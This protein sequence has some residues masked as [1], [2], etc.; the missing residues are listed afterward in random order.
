MADNTENESSAID[1]LKL[2][3]PPVPESSPVK[4]N[5]KTTPDPFPYRHYYAL[6]PTCNKMLA[7]KWDAAQRHKHLKKL[8][9]AKPNVDNTAPK[10]YNHLKVKLKKIQMEEGIYYK[11]LNSRSTSSNSKT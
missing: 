8:A 4:S 9:A 2:V 1:P 11:L 10:V 5:S 6:Y 7:S 3:E